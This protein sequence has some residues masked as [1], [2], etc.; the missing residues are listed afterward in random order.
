MAAAASATHQGGK[1]AEDAE[2]L[3]QPLRILLGVCGSV[4]AVKL[5]ELLN[6]LSRNPLGVAI[7]VVLTDGALKFADVD[8]KPNLSG[9]GTGNSASRSTSSTKNAGLQTN[10]TTKISRLLK[11]PRSHAADSSDSAALSSKVKAET[12]HDANHS[13]KESG[14]SGTRPQH[15]HRW[16]FYTDEDEW[17]KYRTVHEDPVLHID[18]AKRSHLFLIAPLSANTLAKIAHG[19][20]DNLLTC[21]VRAWPADKPLV[22]APAM[23]TVMW[24]NALTQ[25]HLSAIRRVYPLARVIEPRGSALL[26]C[27]DVGVGAMAEVQR[28]REAVRESVVAT[29]FLGA[30]SSKGGYS[31]VQSR[32]ASAL[33]SS[34]TGASTALSSAAPADIP[35]EASRSTTGSGSRLEQGTSEHAKVEEFFKKSTP[36]ADLTAVRQQVAKLVQELS[37]NEKVILVT[38]GGTSVP[39]EKNQ[40]RS[41]ENF[42]TGGRGARCVEEFL[43]QPDALVLPDAAKNDSD[44]LRGSRDR[45][46]EN[47]EARIAS[48]ASPKRRKIKASPQQDGSGKGGGGA[49]IFLYSTNSRELPFVRDTLKAARG[50]LEEA[51]STSDFD[52]GEHVAK[53][54]AGLSRILNMEKSSWAPSLEKL[55]KSR[56][57]FIAIPFSTVYQYL[58]YLRAIVTE[59]Q[60]LGKRAM[61]FL[62]A[63]VSD[64]YVPE[65]DM[66]T[67]KIQS[68]VDGLSL[69]LQPVPK[70]LGE[71]RASWAPNSFLVTF[72]LET[73]SEPFLYEKAKGALKKYRCDCVVANMLQSYRDW[74]TLICYTDP[75]T[76]SSSS[77]GQ[78]QTIKHEKCTCKAPV[79]K[80]PVSKNPAAPEGVSLDSLLVARLLQMQ[81]EVLVKK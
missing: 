27:G 24:Q 57:R 18:L 26:A 72:K 69:T 76:S 6:S 10:S 56:T 37:E 80:S 54:H 2:P 65:K 46:N 67:D 21:C 1:K 43:R 74:A 41:I 28:I 35:A 22:V 4:A 81:N 17:S 38:S 63:A 66:A 29:A 19:L 52:A 71:I 59:L 11:R 5:E 44:S 14:N 61:L 31:D 32:P 36:P 8:Y 16:A 77:G 68:S 50:N 64:F 33:E 78:H 9:G 40:V 7:D 39:L 49:L 12:N 20:C 70:V 60:P 51:R 25:Q 53:L 75:A 3:L 34:S 55:K 42:S 48:P 30:A 15:A 23:N 73:K 58:F 13:S 62:A 45:E 47:A 79:V